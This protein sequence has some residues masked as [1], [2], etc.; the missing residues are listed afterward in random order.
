M[1]RNCRQCGALFAS[2]GS[3]VCPECLAREEE[4]FRSVRAYVV[5]HPDASVEEVAEAVAVEPAVILRFLKQGRLI[6]VRAELTCESCGRPISEGRFCSACVAAL[7]S[8]LGDHT[9]PRSTFYGA[10]RRRPRP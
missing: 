3:D 10:P 2:S 6:G 8:G 9:G 1:L 4:V 7:R 5:D